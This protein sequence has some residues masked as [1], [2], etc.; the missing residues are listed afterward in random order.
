V[1]IPDQIAP[2]EPGCRHEQLRVVHQDEI[3]MSRQPFQEVTSR[4]IGPASPPAFGPRNIE[5]GERAGKS[6]ISD[7]RALVYGSSE[8][9][10]GEASGSQD[11]P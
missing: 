4:P 1:Y 9:R 2:P 11:H 5:A 6:C 3:V 8:I 7:W 10:V